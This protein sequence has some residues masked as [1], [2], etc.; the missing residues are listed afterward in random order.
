MK[1]IRLSYLLAMLILVASCSGES[2]SDE[3]MSTT[4]APTTISVAAATTSRV[5]PSTTTEAP[6][7]TTPPDLVITATDYEYHGVPET[8]PPG[9]TIRLVNASNSEFHSAYIIR[10]PDGDERTREE[11]TAM[12]P[13]D[14]L[15]HY[16]PGRGVMQVV[17]YARPGE[18]QYSMDLGGPRVRA[19]GRYVI[20]CFI[21]VGANPV[22]ME[23]QVPWGPPKQTE[24]VPRHDQV[25]MFAEFTVEG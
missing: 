9:T 21:P 17:I 22:E 18:S 24:G 6:G 10:L 20:M 13:Q 11:L 16:G 25:G 5:V 23:D 12:S 2:N 7:P 15:P 3:A 8:V 14:L 1:A 4:A 19:P